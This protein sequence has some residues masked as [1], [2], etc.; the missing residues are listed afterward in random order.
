[1]IFVDKNNY[2]LFPTPAYGL[3]MPRY[4]SGELSTIL[5]VSEVFILDICLIFFVN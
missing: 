5:Y 4:T 3:F 2:F 1:M